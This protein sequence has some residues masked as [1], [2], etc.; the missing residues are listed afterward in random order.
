MNY[1]HAFHA[2]SFADVMKHALLVRILVHLGRKPAP[3]RVIDTHAGIGRYDLAGPEAERT[4][5]WRTGIGRLDDP[6]APE[7][8]DLL[9]PFRAVV[10]AV[11]SRH[12]PTAYPGSPAILRE[13]LRRDDRAIL[14]EKHPA[15]G[16]LLSERFNA[17]RNLKVLEGD[18][19]AAL[20]GLIPPPERRGLVLID[21]P[22]EEPDELSRSVPRL[23]AASRRWP[24]GTFAL[25]YPVKLAAE[26]DG[27]AKALAADLAAPMLRLELLVE[28][29]DDPR[30]LNGSGLMVIHP[31]WTLAVEAEILMPALAERLGRGPGAG[32]RVEALGPT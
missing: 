1:R 22:Y 29:A 8:E 2:G 11:R 13:L 3:F 4:E 10:A 14:I 17:V 20:G 9:G 30:R 25:W 19:W 31:P 6:F 26:V 27:F 18:G 16:A 24:T 12:G 7:V 15:D 28:R 5:E 23:V 32:F 21:P